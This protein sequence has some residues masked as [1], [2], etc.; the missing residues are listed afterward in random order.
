M[1]ALIHAE[2]SVGSFANNLGNSSVEGDSPG[3]G[4]GNAEHSH[5]RDQ[6][7]EG[8]AIVNWQSILSML[9]DDVELKHVNIVRLHDVIHTESKLVLIFEVS[10]QLVFSGEAQASEVER[11]S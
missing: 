3:R 10:Y 11:D 4:R 5:P 1:S 8:W 2:L 7:D 6:L 9:I